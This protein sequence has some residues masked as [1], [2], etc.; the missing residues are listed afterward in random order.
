MM[1]ALQGT[2]EGALYVTPGSHRGM[3]TEYR[4][5][6]KNSFHEAEIDESFDS[7]EMLVN[8]FSN[9]MVVYYKV[10]LDYSLNFDHSL[11]RKKFKFYDFLARVP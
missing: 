1:R 4:A 9:V 10:W 2:A 5:G 7:R 8:Y 11:F 3:S 6:S